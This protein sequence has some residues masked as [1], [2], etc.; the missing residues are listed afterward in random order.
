LLY[1]YPQELGLNFRQELPKENIIVT[2]KVDQSQFDT[3]L[4]NS[5]QL[6][7]W[8]FIFLW[9]RVKFSLENTCMVLEKVGQIGN[10]L[11]ESWF[12]ERLL[13]SDAGHLGNLVYEVQYT[14]RNADYFIV[15]NFE[16]FS[17]KQSG[18]INEVDSVSFFFFI[19]VDLF[20]KE[21]FHV[22]I[23]V[24]AEELEE[25]KHSA[26][27]FFIVDFCH[28]LKLVEWFIPKLLRDG[29][30]FWVKIV[31]CIFNFICEGSFFASLLDFSYFYEEVSDYFN[32]L[33]NAYQHR[34][35]NIFFQRG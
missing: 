19:I 29:V 8:I 18:L 9:Y 22:D 11:K 31:V 21:S 24:L 28:Q 27:S 35:T 14:W 12:H 7:I 25:S 23:I 3:F 16:K 5:L 10:V 32:V 34:I 26:E 4:I 13:V 1:A 17:K 30:L 33:L 2:F 20:L 15:H 6:I